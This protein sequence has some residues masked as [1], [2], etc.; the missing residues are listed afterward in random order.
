MQ[1]QAVKNAFTGQPLTN[2]PQKYAIFFTPGALAFAK[3]YDT[4]LSF[5]ISGLALEYTENPSSQQDELYQNALDLY[6]NGALAGDCLC[7]L[8]I[9]EIFSW[10]NNPFKM[11]VDA[12]NAWTYMIMA[13]FYSLCTPFGYEIELRPL[14]MDFI[15]A[16]QDDF[17]LKKSLEL[18]KNSNDPVVKRHKPVISQTLIYF[19]DHEL[20]PEVRVEKFRNSLFSLSN[21][22]DEQIIG[23]FLMNIFSGNYEK[24]ANLFE[25]DLVH[26]YFNTQIIQLFA[27]HN[28][29]FTVD[30]EL[31][32]LMVT[33]FAANVWH[34]L[35][36]KGKAYEGEIDDC[37]K[38]L[39][40]MCKFIYNSDGLISVPLAVQQLFIA[41]HAW[42]YRKGFL[43]KKDY[44]KAHSYLSKF[45]DQTTMANLLFDKAKVKEK[46]G[47]TSEA[48]HIYQKIYQ[49]YIE[50]KQTMGESNLMPFDF[51]VLGFLEEKLNKNTKKAK[52]YY[53]K[54]AN[55][56]KLPNYKAF[57]SLA[58]QRKCLRKVEKLEEEADKL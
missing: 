37:L 27:F 14:F 11:K 34:F 43:V 10:K 48:K 24:D 12:N 55:L 53:N 13:M 50:A 44:S 23:C 40:R 58:F 3:Q 31:H 9:S 54:G 45:D 29:T 15:A 18:L 2:W 26:G 4:G 38:E 28:A 56:T 32:A 42:C 25:T 39:L 46:L 36:W 20:A 35:I 6:M 1:P 7:C 22:I 41:I 52:E 49:T 57:E 47:L 51:Y 5:L 16:M 33:G 17:S 21:Y 8:K 19:F 30:G